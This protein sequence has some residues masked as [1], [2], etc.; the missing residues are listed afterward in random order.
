MPDVPK[1][2][3]LFALLALLVPATA[4]H[5]QTEPALTV[6]GA[7]EIRV[8]SDLA[9]VRLGIVGQATTA[10]AAQSQVNQV[11]SEMLE[12]LEEAGID[13]RDVQTARLVLSPVYSRQAPGGGE[14]PEIVA[15]RASN[16]VSVRVED[17]ELVG[18]VIDAGLGA[19]ANTLDGV[20]F[21][22]EDDLPAR[23]AA[24]TEAITEAR[25][26]AA[27]MAEALGVELGRVL[28][29]D[30]GGVFIQPS[31]PDMV[32]MATLQEATPTPVSP[33][34]VTV[35]AS[36]TIRYEIGED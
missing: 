1:L 20:T 14:P 22:I 21:G 11:A 2:R 19:G 31:Q 16:T 3:W 12:A 36:V 33:G 30:E 27:T 6:Q 29:V 13:E 18:E 26:K 24:L 7:S 15:Y 4:A 28:S 25:R 5:A 32:R 35:S 23:E 8:P 17:L 10:D 34:E 9:T